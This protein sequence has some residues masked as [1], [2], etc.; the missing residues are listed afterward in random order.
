MREFT[1]L[2][3]GRLEIMASQ[4]I[5]SYFLPSR[6]VD[7]HQIYPGVALVVSV[8]NSN[9]VVEAIIRGNIELGFVEGTEEELQDSRFAVE[10][11]ARDDLVMVVSVNHRWAN[12]EK[13]N[14]DDLLAGKWVLREDGSGTRAAFVKALDALGIPVGRLNIAIELPSNEQ[15]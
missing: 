9:Q 4:T 1:G 6:L 10:M 14:V 15:L 3:R 5:A 11:I 13:L 7:C 8:G 12:L 2:S